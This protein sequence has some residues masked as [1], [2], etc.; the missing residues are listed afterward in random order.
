MI[1]SIIIQ[2]KNLLE[3]VLAAVY[4]HGLSGDLGVEKLGEKPLV[5]GDIIRYLP[6]GIK[7]LN[8]D[9]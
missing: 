5:A 6:K 2:E 8:R 1:A 3:A 7:L 9:S 4:I